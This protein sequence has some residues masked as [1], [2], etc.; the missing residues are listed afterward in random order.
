MGWSALCLED[1]LT[2]EWGVT[3]AEVNSIAQA[4][5]ISKTEE[6]NISRSESEFIQTKDRA[7]WRTLKL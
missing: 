1:R 7:S 3:A 6:S 4:A 2:N 5:R